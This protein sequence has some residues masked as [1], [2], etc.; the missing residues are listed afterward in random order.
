MSEILLLAASKVAGGRIK[1]C[2]AMKRV[3]EDLEGI[4]EL[5]DTVRQWYAD[6]AEE[7]MVAK[8]WGDGAP[9]KTR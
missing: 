1:D 7:S 2:V 9:R 8:S 4:R 6:A 3:D 5:D